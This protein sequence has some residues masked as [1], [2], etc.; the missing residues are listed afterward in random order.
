MNSDDRSNELSGNFGHENQ[1]TIKDFNDGVVQ[2]T[3][4]CKLYSV[5]KV[6]GLKEWAAF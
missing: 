5:E 2:I 6:H 1:G 3:E 4:V